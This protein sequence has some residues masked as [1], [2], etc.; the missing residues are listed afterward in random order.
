MNR[1]SEKSRKVWEAGMDILLK[2]AKG[3]IQGSDK[4]KIMLVACGHH[5]AMVASEANMETNRLILAKTIYGNPAERE[6]YIKA[7]MPQ[8]LPAKKE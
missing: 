1:D 7:A 2:Y 5:R 3:E 8:M 4:V 6:K